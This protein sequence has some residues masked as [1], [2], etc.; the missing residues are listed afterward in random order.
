MRACLICRLFGE[1]KF[2]DASQTRQSVGSFDWKPVL[3]PQ[4][5]VDQNFIDRLLG[6]IGGEICEVCLTGWTV[7]DI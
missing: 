2:K 6:F 3:R 7:I 1:R 5:A 4:R